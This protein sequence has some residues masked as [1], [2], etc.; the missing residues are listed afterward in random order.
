MSSN[1]GCC[2][3]AASRASSCR[4]LPWGR[5]RARR[6]L[7]VVAGPFEP[8][9]FE[10]LVPRDKKLDPAW[11][12]SLTERRRADVLPRRGAEND[13]HARR[14]HRRRAGLSRRRRHTLALGR[15]QPPD[16][17]RRRP[18]RPPAKAERPLDQG[19]ALRVSWEGKS[20]VRR[21]DH[22]GFADITFRGQYPIGLVE[23]RD[24]AL[25][26]TVTLEAFSPF[27]PLNADDSSLPA[28]VMHFTVKNT[29]ATK[30]EAEIAGWLE[31]AVC[32]D[33]GTPETLPRQNRVTRRD[34]LTCLECRAEPVAPRERAPPP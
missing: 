12:R 32:L 27:I 10:K 20:E 33:S 31:N 15:L 6:A 34:G 16:R 30:V 22:R 5:S 9:D 8:A 29:G 18:L 1:E 25:P 4:S 23:Y 13:R 24:P 17:D 28:T 11:V 7:A 2:G 26:V 3:P 19:F 14:G 21:L